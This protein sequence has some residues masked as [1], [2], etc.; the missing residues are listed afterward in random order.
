VL[1]NAGAALEVAGATGSI[2]DGMG[3]AATS[4]DSGSAA[5]VLERWAGSGGNG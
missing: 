3:L 4:I 1:L 2:A 5:A